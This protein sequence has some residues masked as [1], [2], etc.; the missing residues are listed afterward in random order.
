MKE[1]TFIPALTPGHV[2]EVM[3]PG[4]AETRKRKLRKCGAG[5]TVRN[6]AD[7]TVSI[8]YHERYKEAVEHDY[9]RAARHR[10]TAELKGKD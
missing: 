9:V 4:Q 7:G 1:T 3:T 2:C 10:A 6:R 5:F 8:E